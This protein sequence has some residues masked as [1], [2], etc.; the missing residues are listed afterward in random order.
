M[1]SEAQYSEPGSNLTAQRYDSLSP[2][3]GSRLPPDVPPSAKLQREHLRAKMTSS[4]DTGGTA[5]EQAQL[6]VTRQG[7]A[8]RSLKAAVKDGNASKVGSGYL[9]SSTA[10]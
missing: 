8:V 9:A 5:V 10:A 6:A 7:D 3:K 4:I 2:E 1:L